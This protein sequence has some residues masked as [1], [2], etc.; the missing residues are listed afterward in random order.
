MEVLPALIPSL[1]L[2]WD[3]P[4]A[5]AVV[6]G[7]TSSPPLETIA[8]TA[9]CFFRFC[10][11]S[12]RLRETASRRSS[13]V[14]NLEQVC[15][16]KARNEFPKDMV[17]S[18]SNCKVSSVWRRSLASPCQYAKRKSNS[19]NRLLW[20]SGRRPSKTGMAHFARLLVFS[21]LGPTMLTDKTYLEHVLPIV[22][23]KLLHLGGIAR[24][25]SDCVSTEGGDVSVPIGTR[26]TGSDSHER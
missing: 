8:P 13:L 26:Q 2:S 1:A 7:G 6:D 9:F 18:S 14:W 21:L 4:A 24:K 11:M 5:G 16:L 12:L 20:G 17:T 23:C 19:S 15:T 3:G 22:S 10:E 25:L